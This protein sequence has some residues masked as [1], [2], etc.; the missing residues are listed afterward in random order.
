MKKFIYTLI[1]LLPIALVAQNQFTGIE[2]TVNPGQQGSVADLIELH[3][4][5]A[6]FKSGSGLNLERLWQGRDR[7][8]VV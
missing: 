2:I 7:K 5:D 8:S 6:N 1:L 4:G 3:Y